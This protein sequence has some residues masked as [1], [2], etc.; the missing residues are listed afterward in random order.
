MEQP[1]KL[2]IPDNADREMVIATRPNLVELNRD[3]GYK[4]HIQSRI[5]LTDSTEYLVPVGNQLLKIQT[6]HR[7]TFAKGEECYVD[8]AHVSWYPRESGDADAERA[9]RQ[10]V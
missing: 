6:P 4:T 1:L 5:F 8:L 9:K 10:L 3:H 2:V 7:I